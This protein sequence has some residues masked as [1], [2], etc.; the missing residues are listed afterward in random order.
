M[1]YSTDD[2]LDY[3]ATCCVDHV[4][5]ATA[6]NVPKGHPMHWVAEVV[7]KWCNATGETP[8]SEYNPEKNSTV[9]VVTPDGSCDDT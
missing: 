4:Y 6:Q 2:M 9:P 3:I 7:A 1:S 8:P 5:A